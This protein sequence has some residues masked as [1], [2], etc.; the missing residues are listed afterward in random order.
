RRLNRG[1]RSAL[2]IHGFAHGGVLVEAGHGETPDG[3]TLVAR[4]AL[5]A[6][7]RSVVILPAGRPGL[8]GRGEAV[9]CQQLDD[10]PMPL[11]AT[12]AL[13]RLTVLG[14][15]PALLEQ[16]LE[17]FG[18]ALFDFNAR[19]GEVF[20]SLQG[21]VYASPLLAEVVAFIRGRGVRGVGQSS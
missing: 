9:G 16:D 6:P 1:Q 21:G 4:L 20:A 13:C 15:V 10:S 3:G 7:W 11:T 18:E 5:S 14:M 12:E 8:H 17:A 2:G 19:V